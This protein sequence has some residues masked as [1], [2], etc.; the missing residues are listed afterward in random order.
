MTSPHDQQGAQ[1][2]CE[3]G[4]HGVA[5]LAP[6]CDVVIIV[7]VLSFTTCVDV[8]TAR[9]AIVYPLRYRDGDAECF[10]KELGALVARPRGRRGYSL[11][12]T[13][14]LEIPE[15]TRLVLPSPNGSTLSLATGDTATMAGCLRN[16]EAVA[17]ATSALGT[18]IAVIPAGERW[19]DGS[20]RP[21]IEDWIGAGAIIE[22]LDGTLSPEATAAR[23]TFRSVLPDLES[24]IR[25]CASGRELT[26]IG[27][28]GDV[29]LA[30][31][32]RCSRCVPRL[33]N[34][35]FV[36]VDG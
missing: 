14:L 28:A 9:E 34:D 19:P 3:W 31:A 17:R 36:H 21:A 33:I 26:E 4:E 32:Y 16:A 5:T 12:P 30:A 13:S 8:A 23:D 2:R 22:H 18:T 10:A 11:S 1:V 27:Y 24:T 25:G 15:G 20:L 29:A 35:A 6:G 7:D